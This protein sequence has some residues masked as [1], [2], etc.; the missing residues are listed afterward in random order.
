V[1][2]RDFQ[3]RL[4][5]TGTT[6]GVRPG[7]AILNAALR[8]GHA[9]RYGC[10]H[11]NCSTCKYRLLEGE[12]D[13]G[14]AS[15]YS[16]SETEREQGWALLCC[17]EPLEDVVVEHEVVHDDRA[18]PLL[19]PQERA[20]AV[21]VA[22]PLAGALWDLRIRLDRPLN[23]Y[24]GQFVE[25][26]VGGQP[27]TWRSYSIASSPSQ[28]D[29]LEFVIKKVPNGAFSGSLRERLAGTTLSV[30]GP[31]GHGYLRAGPNT[32]LL[33]AVGSGIAPVRSILRQAAESGDARSFILAY[34]ARDEAGLAVLEPLR[35]LDSSL[36]LDIRPTLTRPASG[37]WTG[38]VGRVIQVVQREVKDARDLDAYL[39]GMPA[40]CD[41]MGLL[42]EAKGIRD[43]AVH[44]D[45]FYPGQ[46]TKREDA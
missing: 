13:F 24:A 40:M 29:E 28:A 9:L 45:R 43:G 25:L 11:G 1:T 5:P 7:E 27:G 32:V 33:V 38:R 26:G 10:R 18:R 19:V 22:R 36:A 37:E 42:L 34:G 12:V 41:S 44:F 20:A 3:V 6:F 46:T 2:G 31:Y 30:R 21:T 16:L 4:E 15:V 8:Q 35:A 14:P 17:A 23:F 39:C